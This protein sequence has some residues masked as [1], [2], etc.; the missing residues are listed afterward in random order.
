MIHS[1]QVLPAAV[2]TDKLE[3]SPCSSSAHEPIDTHCSAAVLS[4]SKEPPR[5]GRARSSP[6]QPYQILTLLVA[7]GLE[8][9]ITSILVLELK[10]E[11][12][13]D[14]PNPRVSSSISGA[15]K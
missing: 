14:M 15:R 2:N 3:M 4:D 11:S 6:L 5:E 1:N 7:L 10:C 13:K 8:D 9:S 12:L